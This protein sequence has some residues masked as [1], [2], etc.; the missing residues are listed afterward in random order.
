[1]AVY[2]S[3]SVLLLYNIGWQYSM[4]AAYAIYVRAAAVL[5]LYNIGREAA[6]VIEVGHTNATGVAACRTGNKKMILS[7]NKRGCCSSMSRLK[8]TSNR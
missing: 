8:K 7:R 1:M 5:L 2:S 4:T 3:S 6:A